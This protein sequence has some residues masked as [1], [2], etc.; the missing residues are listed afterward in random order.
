MAERIE[1]RRIVTYG[2]DPQAD[3]CAT[4]VRPSKDGATFDVIA[5]KRGLG[6]G[7]T[8]HDLFLPVAGRH[9]VQNAVAAVAVARE[10]GVTDQA[11]RKGLKN[12][13]GVKRR[14]STT[15]IWNN[16]RIIDD[17][18]HHPVE[19]AA[20]LEAARE[21]AEGRVIAVVQPHRYSRLRDLFDDFAGCFAAADE[22]AVADVYP[23]G[24]APIE[25]ITADALVSAIRDR[26]HG[27]VVRLPSLT[28]LA[29]FVREHARPGDLVVCL[30]AGDIT[31]HANAL[32]GR[33]AEPS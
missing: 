14:F 30:G 1:E 7:V 4:N 3:V 17:Y 20:V 18:G 22:V 15:G 10:L 33:L 16:V 21:V 29:D 24:E 31:I 11:I 6:E 25:G 28:G 32:P 12:F 23:A 5:R 2:F 27:S 13:A 26:G 9:N 8:L 19:I